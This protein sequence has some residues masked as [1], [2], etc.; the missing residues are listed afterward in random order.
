[1]ITGAARAEA[2]ILVIDA[3]EGIKENSKRH[4]LYA[5]NAWNQANY[6]RCK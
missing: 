2:A 6:S 3:E 4:R 1:M 5:F